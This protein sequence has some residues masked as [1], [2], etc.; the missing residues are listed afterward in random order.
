[1]VWKQSILSHF[2]FLNINNV[3][4]Y[5]PTYHMTAKHQKHIWLVKL[6]SK[7]LIG[8]SIIK[9]PALQETHPIKPPISTHP[10]IDRFKFLTLSSHWTK[11]GF[12]STDR[13]DHLHH[14]QSTNP[15]HYINYESSRDN[16]AQQLNR[17]KEKA[18]Y[19]VDKEM[20]EK[21]I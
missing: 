19:K 21:S 10:L 2:V 1:M 12:F 18:H 16:K 14:I 5:H 11:S 15:R 7:A 3:G 17:F 6:K 8:F 13:R 4:T 20:M 9:Y